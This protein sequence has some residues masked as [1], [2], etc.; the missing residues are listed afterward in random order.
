[1]GIGYTLVVPL[2]DVPASM[3]AVP[4]AAVVGWIEVR[5]EGDPAVVIHPARTA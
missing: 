1:M 2:A 3:A 4:E 5:R